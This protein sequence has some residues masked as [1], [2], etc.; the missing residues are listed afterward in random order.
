MDF[1]I[2]SHIAHN[3][4]MSNILPNPVYNS[5]G[6]R[7]NGRCPVC[8]DS[9][10][11]SRKRRLYMLHDNTHGYVFYC[12]ND[13]CEL[14]DRGVSFINFV[15]EYF[16]HQW[17]YI[18]RDLFGSMDQ[19]LMSNKDEVT[20]VSDDEPL[21]SKENKYENSS[22]LVL[23]EFI[24]KACVP[25]LDDCG[26]PHL[27]GTIKNVRKDLLNKR[28][29]PPEVVDKFYYCW[30]AAGNEGQN[31]GNGKKKKDWRK[32]V[33]RIV[34]PF[35]NRQGGVYYFQARAI[36]NFQTPKYINWD[37]EEGVNKKPVYKE[38]FIDKEKPVIIC[39]GILDCEFAE[40]GC[41]TLGVKFSLEYLN[42]IHKRFGDNIIWVMDN[43][44]GG[45]PKTR[46]LLENDERCFIMPPKYNTVK[47]LNDLATV[48]GVRDLAPFIIENSEE[49]LQGIFNLELRLDKESYYG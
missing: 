29:L 8:G 20:P 34:I 43:D 40:N 16:P 32:Y 31:L 23:E 38:Y 5:A 10:K 7:H 11:N 15:K 4:F 45:D 18:K 37:N 33:N 46:W 27:Q 24:Q 48:M 14:T 44:K 25:L 21:S 49:G 19:L 30:S 35:Y 3:F 39:E 9:S 17:D 26:K 36:T 2:P 47:D 13:D 22:D 41:S 6:N 42:N 12:H 1:D 28:N